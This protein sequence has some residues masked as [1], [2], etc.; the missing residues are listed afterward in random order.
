MMYNQERGLPPACRRAEGIPSAVQAT[1][2][3]HFAD[4]VT[5]RK[6]IE[7]SIPLATLEG[8]I[9]YAIGLLDEADG[10]ADLEPEIAL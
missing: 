8:L 6:L 5:K 7:L 2:D 4:T 3:D 9:E 10:D 1:G